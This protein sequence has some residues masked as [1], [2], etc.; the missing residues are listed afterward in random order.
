MKRL[1]V[2][3]FFLLIAQMQAQYVFSG[4][5]D[6]QR[7]Q[8]DVYLSVIDDYRKL[9]GV[10]SEQIIARTGIDSAGF[11]IFK[12]DQLEQTHRIY[13]IHVD[14][15]ENGIDDPNHIS[16]Q[17]PDWAEVLFLARNTDTIRFPFGFEKEMFCDLESNN[18][19]ANALMQIDSLKEEMRFA[20][21]EFRSEANR[22]LNSR[23]WI[24]TMRE[25]GESLEEPLAEIYSY[26]CVS[27]R[28]SELY[29]YYLIIR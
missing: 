15:C 17:C 24:N 13:R 11:F 20:F 14:N 7:W 1:I 4:Y 9:S 10:Y 3:A 27:E 25:F 12:G 29:E 28:G 18:P 19:K 22:K 26:A 8:G 21:G 6:D 2:I 23:K 16:G 5:V